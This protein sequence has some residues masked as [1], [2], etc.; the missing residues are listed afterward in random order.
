MIKMIKLLVGIIIV[1]AIVAIPFIL[2]QLDFGLRDFF[3]SV[4]AICASGIGVLLIVWALRELNEKRKN[5]IK[6]ASTK[7]DIQ[8]QFG[9]T[10]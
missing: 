10:V 8:S 2:P 6:K 4:A 1:A 9:G 5:K 7:D 3:V